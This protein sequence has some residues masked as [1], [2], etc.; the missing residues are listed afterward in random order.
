M[1]FQKKV[2][3]AKTT[4]MC[5]RK[6]VVTVYCNSLNL[7]GAVTLSLKGNYCRNFGSSTGKL[8]FMVS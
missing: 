1:W 8:L 3:Q 4:K 7:M 5:A 2:K 6:V